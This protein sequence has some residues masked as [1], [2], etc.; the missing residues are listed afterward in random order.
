MTSKRGKNKEVRY[1]LQASS[2]TDVLTSYVCYHS[3]Q[4]RLNKIYLYTLF[5]VIPHKIRNVLKN[6]PS[7][8]LLT[9]N[10]ALHYVIILASVLSSQL[11]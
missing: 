5:P 6:F 1:E 2:V 8:D 7:D 4:A 3:T 9:Q 10:F 11:L